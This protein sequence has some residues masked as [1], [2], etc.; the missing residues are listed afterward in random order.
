MTLTARI[1]C[2][3]SVTLH[4]WID[5][6]HATHK[7]TSGIAPRHVNEASVLCHVGH[8]DQ[9]ALFCFCNLNLFSLEKW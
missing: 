4:T 7:L 3:L 8:F 5:G 2:T 6:A 1:N 9:K